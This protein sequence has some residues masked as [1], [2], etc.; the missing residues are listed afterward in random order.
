[1]AKKSKSKTAEAEDAE[2][3]EEVTAE[4]VISEEVSS[5]VDDATASQEDDAVAEDDTANP[6]EDTEEE[7][8]ASL[9]ARVLRGL[10]LIFLGIVI[11]LWGAPK[12][13]PLLPAGLAPVAAFLTPGQT[14]AQ[15]DIAALRAEME[16]KLAA[17]PQG[18]QGV[19]EAALS[20]AIAQSLDPV[21]A[22][23]T[24]ELAAIKDRLAATDGQEVE[25]RLAALESRIEGINGELTA[26]GERLSTQITENGAALSEE[27]AAKLAGY[28]AVLEGLK[29]Q[30]ADLAAKN[31]A[32]SQKVEDIAAASARRV[33]EAEVTAAARVATTAMKQ[34]LTDISAALASGAPF[35]GALAEL[36]T[37]TDV[38]MPEALSAIADTGT[39]SLT[40]LR[41]G[42]A[43][44]AHDAL[45]ADAKANAGDGLTSKLGA[46]LKTQVG[47]R[48]LDRQEGD[49]TDAILSRVEDDLT[50]GRLSAA[51]SEANTLAPAPKEAFADWIEDLGTLSAAQNALADLSN[52]LGASQ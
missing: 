21:Q 8:R 44:N 11:A 12:L 36:A 9:A 14:E 6:E 23:M 17:V 5:E 25:A 37:L 32:L 50:N 35:Q 45:R 29:A 51:L 24:E 39:P 3:V 19:D 34:N 52:S 46:F 13:A 7:V 31:G 41:N 49:S 1:M 30:V 18:S 26:V 47:S 38:A 43:A 2:I 15:T 42:F 48:S 33:E 20:A 27:A 10:F 4:E 22:Q 16:Q 40:T 28:Q